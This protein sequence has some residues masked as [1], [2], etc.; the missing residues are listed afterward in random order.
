MKSYTLKK[1]RNKEELHLF[2]GEIKNKTECTSNYNSI[3]YKMKKDESSMNLFA[4]F[5]DEEA[6]IEIA[7]IGRKVCGICV[8]HLYESY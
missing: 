3:C 5:T 7:N 8:S 4:C 2:E 1:K 6:R